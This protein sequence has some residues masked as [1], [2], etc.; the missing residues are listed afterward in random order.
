[1]LSDSLA[2]A[3]GQLGVTS[4]TYHRWRQEFGRPKND[5]AK[6]SKESEQEA[7]K[8]IVEGEVSVVR[9]ARGMAGILPLSMA[10][11][12]ARSL[13][14]RRRSDQGVGGDCTNQGT[15]HCH[16]SLRAEALHAS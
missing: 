12:P 4:A 16:N 2:D 15:T 13:C 6:R 7:S 1:M 11:R 3:I 14:V 8:R 9:P 10:D 5:Q